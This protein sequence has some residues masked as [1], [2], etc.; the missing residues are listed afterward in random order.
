L[1]GKGKGKEKNCEEI[2]TCLFRDPTKP[3]ISEPK[4]KTQ[5]I[6]VEPR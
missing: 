3:R 5:K 2:T 4:K 6:K 1:K